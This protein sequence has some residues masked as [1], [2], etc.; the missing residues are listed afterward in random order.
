MALA[1]HIAGYCDSLSYSCRSCSRR[2]QKLHLNGRYRVSSEHNVHHC[3]ILL[4]KS[5]HR[6]VDRIRC[7]PAYGSFRIALGDS[8][9]AD[10]RWVHPMA[11]DRRRLHC[12]RALEVHRKWANRDRVDRRHPCVLMVM[13]MNRSKARRNVRSGNWKRKWD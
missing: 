6:M 12:V 9:F 1:R 10:C 5:C 7:W 3:K 8:W 4:R 2:S 11:M 13:R